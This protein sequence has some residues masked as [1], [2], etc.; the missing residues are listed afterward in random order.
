M[1][2]HTEI[3]INASPETVWQ[4]L[5]DFASYPAW[6]PVI[7]RINGTPTV[8]EKISF[9]I[10]AAPFVQIPIPL[11]EILVASGRELRWKGP[12]L[13]LIDQV[14]SGEHYFIVQEAGP[15]K[16]RF[17]HGESFTGYVASVL[18]PILQQRLTES[19]STM[20]RALKERCER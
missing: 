19:Y 10:Q 3:E 5:S 6:N 11:C 13:P 2:I 4:V 8:G 1:E 7:T 14:L 17:V 9:T 18:E 16:V 20:N 15:K 12:A